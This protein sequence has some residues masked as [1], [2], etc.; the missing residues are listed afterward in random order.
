MLSILVSWLLS[1]VAL[2]VV[3][4]VIPGFKVKNFSTALIA[5]IVIGLVN[6]TLGV[7]LG[8]LAFPI[9]FLTLGAFSFVVS[10]VLLKVAAAVMPGF[11]IDGC[12]PALLGAVLLA[13]VNGLMRLVL[14]F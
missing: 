12:L 14:P 5:S 2:I 3:A 7:V 6:A 10:A 8:F 4:N 9:T 13:I 1:A 11:E